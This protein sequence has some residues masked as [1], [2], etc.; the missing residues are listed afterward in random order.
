MNYW[1][2]SA[3]HSPCMRSRRCQQKNGTW[4][5]E[6]AAEKKSQAQCGQKDRQKTSIWYPA[7]CRRD[8]VRW[9]YPCLYDLSA[10]TIR[11]PAPA[12]PNLET[13][14]GLS[15]ENRKQ[16]SPLWLSWYNPR[17][18]PS[19]STASQSDSDAHRRFRWKN[20]RRCVRRVACARSIVQFPVSLRVLKDKSRSRYQT[21]PGSRSGT[22]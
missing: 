1:F 19:P 8:R 11:E 9:K 6:N 17:S 16:L 2:L 20:R 13:H 7:F 15:P 10:H 14:T 4:Y 22:G 3:L 5:S 12:F 18:L 21:L